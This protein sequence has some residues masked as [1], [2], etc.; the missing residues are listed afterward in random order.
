MKTLSRGLKA[1]ILAQN[2]QEYKNEVFWGDDRLE[3]CLKWIHS[4]D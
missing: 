4:K 3:D 1:L 2:S